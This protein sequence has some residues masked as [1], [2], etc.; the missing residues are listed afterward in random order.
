MSRSL[1][2]EMVYEELNATTLMG[3]ILDLGGYHA[4]AY[5]SL[6]QGEH[7]FQTANLNGE[8]RDDFNFNFEN[9]FPT[10]AESF[11][12]IICLNVLEHVFNY[13]N[14][15][16]ESCRTLKK[17]GT[18]VLAVPFLIQYHPSPN[19]H[20]RYTEA[21][22]AIIFE[23]AGFTDIQIQPIG[24]GICSAGYSLIHPL[25][26]FSFVQYIGKTLA[27]FLDGL[28]Q[29]LRPKSFFTKKYYPL[30]YMVIARK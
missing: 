19:D 5:H 23:R 18:I 16:N 29:R 20:W 26:Y 3:D 6:I 27:K 24:T 4:S 13:Q 11:D 9:L 10:R 2:R 14:L 15:L 22:L 17:G 1:W 25:C 7:T 30:G 8:E 12:H 21:T 28:V